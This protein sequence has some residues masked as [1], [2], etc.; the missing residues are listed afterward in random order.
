MTLVAIAVAFILNDLAL[1]D[2][3]YPVANGGKAHPLSF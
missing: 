1:E 2:T 3:H